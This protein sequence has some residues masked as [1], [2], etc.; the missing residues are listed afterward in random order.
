M[1]QT[2]LFVL[3]LELC[4]GDVV[5]GAAW[6]GWHSSGRFDSGNRLAGLICQMGQ[7]VVQTWC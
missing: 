2:L 4:L 5:L 7:P 1:K 6:N 3:Q